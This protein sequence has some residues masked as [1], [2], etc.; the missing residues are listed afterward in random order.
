MP[1]TRHKAALDRLYHRYNRRRF[2]HPDPLEFLYQYEDPR[3][4]EVV[5][6]LASALAYGRVEQILKSVGG[7]LEPMGP[8]PA[9][10]VR[11]S[12]A[13]G[14]RRD[15]GHFR[16]RFQTCRELSALLLGI[17]AVL[18]RH[19]SLEACFAA[20]LERGAQTAADALA[21]LVGELHRPVS[22]R[23]GHLLP[24]PAKGSACKRLNL[25]LRWMIRCDD[26]DVGVWSAMP[27]AMLLVPLDTH[28]HRIGLELALT[29][30]KAADV[31][32]AVEMTA[33]FRAIRPDDP[34][35]YDFALTRLG[36]RNDGDIG[37]FL[38][39]RRAEGADHD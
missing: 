12:N 1:L 8:S 31:R 24:H 38:A 35:R 17:K 19:G 25:F 10:Y 36:I 21:A 39:A 4:R 2:V 16:H 5:G 9:R 29:R 11:D 33:A 23:A 26:V 14:L 7:V 13:G 22:G 32:T 37:A 30:R 28:M 34:V 18:K 27:A 3:D 20:G 15:F 6:L